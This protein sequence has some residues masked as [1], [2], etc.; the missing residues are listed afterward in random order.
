MVAQAPVWV[1]A[2]PMGAGPMEA[3][4]VGGGSGA[5]T[6]LAGG[7]GGVWQLSNQSWTALS[8]GVPVSALAVSSQGTIV[9]GTGDLHGARTWGGVGLEVSSDGG[10]S[11][12]RLAGAAL[13]GMA[14]SRVLLNPNNPQQIL[15]AAVAA[16]DSGPGAQP[17]LYESDDGGATWTLSLGGGVWDVARSGTSLLAVGSASVEW[18]VGGGA[19]VPVASASLPAGWVRGTAVAAGGGGFL[20]ALAGPTGAVSVWQIAASGAVT[21]LPAPP[22]VANARG[23]AL[24]ESSTG[25][26][27]VG[28]QEVAESSDAGGHWSTDAVNGTVHALAALG[29]GAAWVGSDQG[30]WQA[31]GGTTAISMNAGLANVSLLAATHSTSVVLGAVDGGG[32][33]GWPATAGGE[34]AALA[35]AAAEVCA[36]RAADGGL[37][38]TADGGSHWTAA[39]GSYSSL[40]AGSSGFWLGTTGGQVVDPSGVAHTLGSGRVAALAAGSAGVWAS[41]GDTLYLSHDGGTTWQAN[42]TTAQ[43]VT[44]IAVAGTDSNLVAVAA[45]ATVEASVDGGLTWNEISGGL[46]QAPITGLAFDGGEQL[47]A[48]T[49]GRGWWT[50]DFSSAQETVTLSA[51]TTT[52]TAGT[53][54]TITATVNALGQ[55]VT[56]GSGV[57]F[58][59]SQSQFQ[60]WSQTDY[61]LT[62]TPLQAGSWSVEAQYGS[63]TAQMALQVNAAATS[64]LQV[65]SG[66]NQQQAMGTLLSAPIVLLA[67]DGWANPVPGAVVNLSGG[68]FS[69]AVLTT[70]ADGTASANLRLPNTVSTVTLTASTAGAASVSWQE[71]A[72]PAP[73]YALVLTPP[74]AAIAP[75]QSGTLLAT[76]N[77]SGGYT[78]PVPLTCV[79]PSGGCRIAPAMLSPGQT[80]QVTVSAS[81]NQPEMT[82]V[83]AADSAHQASANLKLQAFTLAPGTLS[84]N[85][86][87]GQSSTPMPLQL[88]SVNGLSGGVALTVA[89]L[90]AGLTP[91]FQPSPANLA[92]SGVPATVQFSLLAAQSSQ[93]PAGGLGLLLA[94]G[95]WLLA[96]MKCRGKRWRWVMAVCLLAAGCGGGAGPPPPPAR[97]PVVNTYNLQVTAVVS[98]L[99]A[100]VPLTVNLISQ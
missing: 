61:S 32:I 72:L 78:A 14:V 27:W 12:N 28:G 38:C 17:G 83:I 63:A 71:T 15:A 77:P 2:G 93:G 98:G 96:E 13:G 90:P 54:V 11:W 60:D 91:V 85:V 97:A 8:D 42:L 64:R 65:V 59:A 36:L 16:S 79:Q 56:S 31:G 4:V 46:T 43:P 81:G 26:I 45:G 33:L 84:V 48:A 5:P 3:L 74:A 51:A 86:N 55:P 80:A 7:A 94:A 39:S 50:A 37:T 6:L 49:L 18:S 25:E 67:T 76:L 87:A 21:G 73:D 29:N 40:A 24:A 34:Y 75:G 57:N 58:S 41:V 82:V 62:F 22:L 20:L 89:G 23:L 53:P 52:I 44:A 100:T 66:Q 92:A 19:W 68:N 1:P 70:G 30:V 88:T 95:A 69:S 9:A 99:S 35:A 10:Q 47:W